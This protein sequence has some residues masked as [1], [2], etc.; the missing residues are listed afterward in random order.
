[1]AAPRGAGVG[2]RRVAEVVSSAAQVAAIR[3]AR[4][5]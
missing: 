1:M 4:F 2:E 3:S 5:W